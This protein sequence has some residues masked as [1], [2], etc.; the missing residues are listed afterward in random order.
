MK[1]A[2]AG[3]P[4]TDLLN[5]LNIV[6]P[7]DVLVGLECSPITVVGVGQSQ[8][9]ASPVCCQDNN[10]VSTFPGNSSEQPP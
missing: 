8:C 2:G 6:V 9:D 4:I 5:L 10:V 3:G 1:Q 7:L